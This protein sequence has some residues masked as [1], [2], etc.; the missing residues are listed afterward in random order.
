PDRIV[1]LGEGA[2]PLSYIR[3]NVLASGKAL[4]K[5]HA[6]AAVAAVNAHVAE[7]AAGLIEVD[8]EVLPCVLTAPDA[9]RDCG[10]ILHNDPRPKELGEQPHQVS[11]VPQHFR[12]TR[13]DT[14]KAFAEA[15][16]IV[17]RESH[18]ATVHQGYIEPHNATVLWN[19][20]GRVHI[21][22]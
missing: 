8:Y 3:G 10:P 18:T 4:Y 2:T 21:W 16:L 14:K 6:V 11:N 17:E 15:A 13:G 22:C 19:N 20:D 1:D 5:G 12:S 9:M 7:E